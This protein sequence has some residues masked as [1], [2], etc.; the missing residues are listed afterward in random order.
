MLPASAPAGLTGQVYAT[1]HETDPSTGRFRVLGVVPVRID[2]V[3]AGATLQVTCTK[4]DALIASS[5]GARSSNATAQPSAAD[6][7]AYV[8]QALADRPRL[9]SVLRAP[10]LAR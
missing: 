7:L 3:A 5:N 10:V 8:D 4:L 9:F 1:V 6:D 2:G